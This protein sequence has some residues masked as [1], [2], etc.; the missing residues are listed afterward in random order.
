MAG[1][2]D[3]FWGGTLTAANCEEVAAVIERML[4]GKL[5]AVAAWHEEDGLLELTVYCRPEF[6]EDSPEVWPQRW[7]PKVASSGWTESTGDESRRGCQSVP[8]ARDQPHSRR[9]S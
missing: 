2:V 4:A 1:S 5:F 9:A 3:R 7:V 8:P 6:W